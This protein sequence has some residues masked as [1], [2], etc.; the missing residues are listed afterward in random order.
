[1]DVRWCQMRIKT[2][3]DSILLINCLGL[4]VFSPCNFLWRSL[5]EHSYRLK[6]T[7]RLSSFFTFT[8]IRTV[9]IISKQLLS[10]FHH[11]I[12]K[13]H[14]RDCYNQKMCF[15]HALAVWCTLLIS[16]NYN[17]KHKTLPTARKFVLDQ[18]LFN[19]CNIFRPI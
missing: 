18:K 8:H 1:M 13:L 4:K 19:T 6:T 5:S 12:W 2:H 17:N 3:T 15:Y 11:H 14:C 16:N 10:L 9:F 7:F